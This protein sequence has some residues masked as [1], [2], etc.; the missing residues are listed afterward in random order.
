MNH[1][2]KFVK[3]HFLSKQREAND[4]NKEIINEYL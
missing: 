3:E 1:L 4:L 2:E